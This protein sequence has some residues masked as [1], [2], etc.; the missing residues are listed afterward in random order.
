MSNEIKYEVGSMKDE[1]Q[2]RAY[3][4]RKT[5]RASATLE[6]W[7]SLATLREIASPLRGSQ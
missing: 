3:V 6:V 2:M 1:A 4:K 5:S 7:L